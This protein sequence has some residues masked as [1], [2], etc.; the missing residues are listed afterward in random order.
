MTNGVD[1]FY[2]T[3]HRIAVTDRNGQDGVVFKP[4]VCNLSQLRQLGRRPAT[5]A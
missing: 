5:Q 2:D 4:S 1:K 3:L